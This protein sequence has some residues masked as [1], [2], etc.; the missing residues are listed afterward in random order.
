MNQKTILFLSPSNKLLGA[1]ISLITLIKALDPK[2]YRP[3]VVSLDNDDGLLEELEKIGVKYYRLRLWNWRKGKF[4]WRIPGT[5]Y[6]LNQIVKKEKV[7]LIHSNEFWCMPYAT[8][9]GKYL[10]KIP[11]ISHIRLDITEKKARQYWLA[12]ADRIICVSKA[13]ASLL[14]NWKHSKKVCAVYNGL[15]LTGFD[16]YD[17]RRDT[18]RK[19]FDLK[20]DDI[21]IGEIA[22][23]DE[24]KNQHRVIE[25]IPDI[26]KK[27]PNAY[28]M[29]FGAARHKEYHQHLC[30]QIYE[31][32]IEKHC[33]LTGFRNDVPNLCSGLD[34]TILPSNREGFGRALIEAMYMFTPAVGSNIGGIPE[35]IADKECGYIFKLKH[36]S[37]LS[38]K[39][40]LLITDKKL[41][42][43]MAEKA[44]QR[45]LENFTAQIYAQNI[46]AIY[47]Q[48]LTEYNR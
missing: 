27:H 28:F 18:F 15:D 8:I 14:D 7:A 16:D 5:L 6:R 21:L 4:W 40:N 10:N 13:T 46:S 30:E 9:V 42:L 48:L 36:F 1:R 39:I 37:Q 34:I 25:L 24:R 33:I 11:V 43:K 32:G 45:V 31:L 12:G 20:H 23:L 35:V 19:E 47:H 26:I 2:R 22:Q 29:F 38:E 17:H 44:H 41:R 3:I